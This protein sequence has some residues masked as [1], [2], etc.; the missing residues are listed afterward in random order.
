MKKAYTGTFVLGKQGMV[1]GLFAGTRQQLAA[2][3]GRKSASETSFSW[4]AVDDPTDIATAHAHLGKMLWRGMNDDGAWQLVL[5]QATPA[6]APVTRPGYAVTRLNSTDGELATI[7]W[8]TPAGGVLLGVAAEQADVIMAATTGAGGPVAQFNLD[9]LT[10]ARLQAALWQARSQ[11]LVDLLSEIE[12]CLNDAE[13]PRESIL[14][15]LH[16]IWRVGSDGNQDGWITRTRRLPVEKWVGKTV[17]MQ[18]DVL[19]A[20][21]DV[22]LPSVKPGAIHA[23]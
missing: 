10:Q 5:G 14:E 3:L 11:E 17:L 19:N 8:R 20:E 21:I 7:E 12:G 2:A 22:T 15:F 1:M 4:W 6:K 16:E 9:E 18:V 23:H 13:R